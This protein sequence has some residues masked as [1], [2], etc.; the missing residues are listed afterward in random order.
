MTKIVA[1]EQV[2]YRLRNQAGCGVVA[3]DAGE[4]V[5]L[6]DSADPAVAYRLRP[7]GDGTLVWLG[8]GLQAVG[9]V[10]G[11]PLDDEGKDAA[12]RLMNGCDPRTGARLVKSSARAH[13][14]AQLT[15]VRVIEA[16]EAKAAAAGV[17]PV[18]LF[19]GKPKQAAMF[20]RQQR[21]VH[22]WGETHRLLVT[23]V[24]KFARAAGVDLADVYGEKEL[25]AAWANKDVRVDDRV[26]GWDLVLHLPKSD[27]V[28]P[29]LMGEDGERAYRDLV[30]EATRDTFT[31]LESWIGYAVGSQDA[32]PVRLATGGLLAWSVEHLSARPVVDGEPGDPH[33]HRHVTIANIALCEDGK[34]R[35]I[36]NSGQDLHRH[37]RAADAYFKARVRALAY[38]RFGV[39]RTYNEANREWEVDGIPAEVRD[40]FSRRAAAVTAAV[41][42]DATREEQQREGGLQRREKHDADAAGMRVSWRERAADMLGGTGAVDA[43]V[44]AAAPGPPGPGDGAGADG[45]GTGPRI[46]PPAD[47]AAVVFDPDTGVTSSSKDF[48][49]AQLLAAVGNALQEGI[50]SAP[51]RLDE[52]VDA[53]LAV[54]GYA[55]RLPHV[56]STVMSSMARF[57]TRDILDAEALCVQQALARVDAGAVQ[58]LA[59]QAVAA[60]SVYEVAVGF[61]LSTQQ[62]DVVARVLTGGLGVEAV[63]GVAGAG[64]STLMEAC[65]IGWDAAGTTYAGAC[66]SAV[67]AQGLADASGI[68]SRTVASWLQR[69]RDGKGLAGV[70]VLVVDEATMVDDRSAAALL[71]EA[72]RTGTKLVAVGD[73]LQLQAIGAGGWFKEVHRLVGGLTLTENRRQVDAAERAALEV[74]RTGDHEQAL[75][76]LADRGR[77]HAVET[78]EEALS[79]I[80]TTWNEARTRWEDPH[81]V[82]ESLAVLAARN[83][84]VDLLNAGAQQI[85][86][87]AGELGTEH[88]Y[89]LPGGRQLTLAEGDFVRVRANDYRSR[90]GAGPDLLNGYRAVVTA[91]GEDHSVEITWRVRDAGAEGGHRYESATVPVDQV[92][93]GALS[94]GYAMT[95]AASQGLTT[96]VSLLYGHGANAFAVYPGITRGRQENH[97]WLPLAVV[98][99]EDTRARLGAARSERERLQRAVTAFAQYLGQDKG[100][101]MVSD[102]LREPPEPAV[103]PAQAVRPREAAQEP[104]DGPALPSP[105]DPAQAEATAA[106]EAVR[107]RAAAARATSPLRSKRPA[108]SA[109]A[110]APRPAEPPEPQPELTGDQR[111]QLADFERSREQ[112]AVPSWS[113]RAARPYGRRSDAELVRLAADY[114]QRAKLAEQAAAAAALKAKEM[115]ERL[116]R[117]RTAGATRG[118]LAAADV[119]GVLDEADRH[120]QAARVH[121]EQADAVRAELA[122]TETAL[123]ALDKHKDLNRAQLRLAGTSRKEHT[124]L[125]AHHRAAFAEQT[126]ALFRADAA[127]RDGADTAWRTVRTDP[128]AKPLQGQIA[129]QPPRGVDETAHRL[130]VL[131]RALP[132]LARRIDRTDLEDVARLHGNAARSSQDATGNRVNAAA[133]RSEQKLRASIAARHPELHDTESQARRAHLAQQRAQREQQAREAAAHQGRRYEPPAPKR[134]GPSMGR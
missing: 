82:L 107:R 18:E 102:L 9:L 127:A 15:V 6:D 21:M 129:G 86:R 78:A 37:A 110:P 81:Q 108:E 134:G 70:D 69:I 39:R 61:E 55:V 123:T 73:P 16:I 57:T 62:R 43:M 104:P 24:H 131:R 83:D 120:L 64:K 94:L 23:T 56:G 80:L 109:G 53:V 112:R 5:V 66:L 91:I 113:D 122:R 35:A 115:D 4:T 38:E 132:E 44:A 20:A 46:P 67:A 71:A 117:E 58:L 11:Q 95:V 47:I 111:R 33:L 7:E 93:G 105:A 34:W 65:R 76:L 8:S 98:E 100:D 54:E 32:Q 101:R 133:V 1:D 22:R 40:G 63:V 48:T 90:R 74:W 77:V 45:P 28:L 17:E 52:L 42:E 2:E 106:Q 85:R 124:K 50:D 88:T 75:T 79:Q 25:A 49:R 96:Q 130:A 13:P 119:A 87:A 97:L 59:D 103:L 128:A 60:V 30:H 26:R 125:T 89:A 19:A 51:G 84:T 14:D 29:G 92:V 118:Q 36:A 41:G 99:S 12:R 27:S 121:Q 31:Q 114:D 3:E 10:A 72:A 68:P 126:T 116:E